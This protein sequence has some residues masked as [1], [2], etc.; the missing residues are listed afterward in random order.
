MPPP[1]KTY[2]IQAFAELAGV[3][4]RTLHH[5]DRLGLLVPQRRPGGSRADANGYRLYTAADLERL[6][7]IVA[8]R[9]LGFPLRQIQAL[10]VR[11][12]LPLK[13]AL[14]LQQSLLRQKRQQLDRALE[15]IQ[16]SLAVAR[17]NSTLI[18]TILQELTMSSQQQEWTDKYYSEAAKAKIV[19]RAPSF[20]PAMQESVSRQWAELV[21][22]VEAALGEDPTSPKV[23]ALAARWKKLVEG[24]TQRDPEVTAGL[25]KVWADRQN[26]PADLQQKTAPFRPEV[27]EFLRK[28]LA[29][30]AAS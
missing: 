24:F 26:W 4:V 2:R 12:A 28:A 22:E 20:T 9:F 30:A 3:T 25:K 1:S 13:Q 8:L 10:L 17:P 14:R 5:Y 18:K 16:I 23:Q 7:Q 15:A 19:A 6:E 11:R 21:A 27:M 29:Q